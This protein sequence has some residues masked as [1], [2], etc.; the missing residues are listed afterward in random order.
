MPEYHDVVWMHGGVQTSVPGGVVYLC[1][2]PPESQGD[3]WLGDAR[4]DR[5]ADGI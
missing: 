5:H 1:S 2:M 3:A 4:F